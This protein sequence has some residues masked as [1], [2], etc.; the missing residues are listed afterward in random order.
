MRF[1]L[2]ATLLLISTVQFSIAQNWIQKVPATSA[3]AREAHAM[4][5]DSAR[6]QVVLFGGDVNGAF[7]QLSDTWVWDGSTWTQKFPAN[8][9]SPRIL[10]AMAYDA[11]RQQVVLFGG[12]S[13]TD[14][15]AV[16][17]TWVWDGVNWTQRFPTT[18]PPGRAFSA[19]VYD[20][21]RS[22]VV[23]FG[24]N[25]NAN[26]SSD[27]WVWDGS[28]WT[29]K[30][31]A[32]VPP[33]RFGH[34]MAYDEVRSQV[35][36]FSGSRAPAP[37]L[38]DT[39]VWDGNNW[40]QKLP[41]TS[42]SARGLGA[43]SFDAQSGKVVLFGGL[44]LSGIVTGLSDTWTWNGGNWTKQVLQTSPQARNQHA[45]AY[46]GAR[47]QIVLFGGN[48]NT[49]PTPLGDTWVL[50]M[51]PA[52]CIADAISVSIDF[53]DRCL[54]PGI[55]PSW[56]KMFGDGTS[57]D[58]T[59]SLAFNDGR[60]PA[61]AYMAWYTN[62]H[63][64]RSRI[65]Q[66]LFRDG[67]NLANYTVGHLAANAA[68]SCLAS[69]DWTNLDGGSNDGPRYATD[70]LGNPIIL[71][72]NIEPYLDLVQYHFNANTNKLSWEDEKFTYPNG[73]MTADDG[74]LSEIVEG[75]L[76]PVRPLTYSVDPL[77]GP[78]TEGM[79]NTVWVEMQADT[80]GAMRF[81]P[82]CD[83]N[84]DGVCD[85]RDESLLNA[86]LNTCQG[87]PGYIPRL[88]A[89]GDGCITAKEVA[90]VQVSFV[91]YRAGC[92]RS[93]GYWKNH[94]ADWPISV[95]S[96]GGQQYSQV[97]LLAILAT[98]VR[99]NGAV[100]LAQQLIAAELNIA[101][102]ASPVAAPKDSADA[103]IL[104]L[105]PGRLPPFGNA[106]LSPALASVYVDTLTRYNEGLIGPPACA[107]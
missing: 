75:L 9:P 50:G 66:C 82:G 89:D 24:G 70:F 100:S 26:S 36:L 52:T 13:N 5:Y 28:T 62:T 31:P 44:G 71:T 25:A 38:D 77:V 10:S 30:F 106:T 61:P 103:V 29:Q 88:D 107:Q 1:L 97:E 41:T 58:V 6:H 55:T 73:T 11:A 87:Q 8:H 27:T 81:I 21:A 96:I 4:T 63:G 101:A 72:T 68:Q 90:A 64:Q 3:S 12:S 59:C 74:T 78:E 60:F 42:P 49:P 51:P 83:L 69:V 40:T 94:S 67:L 34:V 18:S 99:G 23:L 57:L 53:A 47:G 17:Q 84:A 37:P 32:T 91:N 46:D 93:H 92:T 98:A 7:T 45:M 104:N 43:M 33:A 102:G 65:A 14:L 20:S 56:S 54:F 39:W 19:M 85:S 48:P 2:S 76:Q 22:E 86:A 35:V 79:F 95:L 16:S 15:A 105:A 80:G